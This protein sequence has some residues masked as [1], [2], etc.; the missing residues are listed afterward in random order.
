MKMNRRTFVLIAVGSL[1]TVLII[2]CLLIIYVLYIPLSPKK[3]ARDV[4][5]IV[6][7]GAS[8]GEVA[9]EL[10]DKQV[11]RSL[12]QFK[13]TAELYKKTGKLRVGKF[14]LKEGMSNYRALMALV[15]GPQSYINFTLPDGY[16]SRRFARI[17]E[18]HLEID[19]T[20]IVT[21]V[22]DSIFIGELGLATR[23]LEGYLFPE[24]YSFTYGV[25]AEHVLTALVSQFKRVVNDS[26]MQKAAEKGWSLNDVLT[27]ASII[28][29]EALVDGEMP[30][31]SSV[32]H[33]RLRIGMPLQADPTIQYIIPDG[34]R[35]LLYRDLDIDSPYNTYKYR[36][37]PPGPI[38]NPGI[39]AIKAA[40]FPAESNYL[41]FVANGDGTHSFSE[42]YTQHLRA[43]ERFDA[44]RRQVVK[45]EQQKVRDEQ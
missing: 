9:I 27:L 30:I 16:D 22:S 15:E 17:I 28:E 34:P 23:S 19:S 11:V 13:L 37:L 42:N 1:L 18:H 45:E 8:L 6:R 35:R 39:H 31:I 29:G 12:D 43:K 4:D 36:G 41:Y 7:W 21:L 44:Y 38:N 20:E 32:Y 24:T 40:I 3:S 14:T 2:G 5:I 25:S 26:L 33:N 10:E